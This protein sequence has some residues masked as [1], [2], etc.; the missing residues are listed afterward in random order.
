VAK[1]ALHPES[2]RPAL[3][4]C[5]AHVRVH[6]PQTL[7]HK[8]KG[9]PSEGIVPCMYQSGY[10]SPQNQP[11]ILFSM[12]VLTYLLEHHPQ[13]C[14]VCWPWKKYFS[15]PRLVISFFFAALTHKTKNW[16]CK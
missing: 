4:P 7:V 1:C 5:W 16:D 8:A 10:V 6:H 12:K 15:H 13:R 2:D 14:S 11:P 9:A 3:A